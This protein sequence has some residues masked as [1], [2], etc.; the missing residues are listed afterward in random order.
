MA[1]LVH[2]YWPLLRAVSVNHTLLEK[3]TEKRFTSS[4]RWM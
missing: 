1:Q 4:G 3:Q 2:I